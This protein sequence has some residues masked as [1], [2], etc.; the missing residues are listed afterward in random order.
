MNKYIFITGIIGPLT[1]LSLI[2]IDISLSGYFSWYVNSLS[3]LGIH[4]YYYLFD[5]AVIFEG[6]MNTIFA[7]SLYAIYPIKFLSIGMIIIGS[8]GL[9]FVG[10]FNENTGI[11]HLTFAL[12]YFII[13]PLG[14]IIFSLFRISKY[15]C[16]Y[17]YSI[18]IVSLITIISGILIDF[19]Y[20]NIKI[21][22]SVTET[23][24]ALLLGSWSIII[25]TYTIKNY[26]KLEKARY[27]NV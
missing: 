14:I 2:F 9:F 16:I 23:I 3:S 5:S 22:L 12:I 8:I 17:G 15:I 6:V 27:I 26:D 13:L 24:E 10:I 4:N 19:H 18:G 20:I 25:G 1:T 11:L 21:G 7:I